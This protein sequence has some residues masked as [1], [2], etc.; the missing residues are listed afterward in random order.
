MKIR[1]NGHSSFT[2]ITDDGVIIVT[3]PYESGAFGGG[4][5]YFPVDAEPDIV[6]ISHNHAD[7][8][9][10]AGFKG[11]FEEVRGDRTI[12]G[13][14]F[15]SIDTYHD[16]N[17]GADRG[18]NKIFCFTI[19]D[20]NVCH[21]GDLGHTLSADQIEKLGSVDVMFMPVGGFYTIDAKQATDIFEKVRPKI[22]IPMH[23]KTEKCGFP[24]A[25]VDEFSRG[26]ARV[27]RIDSDEI[28]LSADK[29]PGEPE[30]IILKH[31]L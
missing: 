14:E 28:E 22:A 24:I 10:T 31:R 2:I 18:D 4:I 17:Q 5:A 15:K 27:Q 25:D 9:Y 6:T 23:F 19:D 29:L 26:K 20:I 30:I 7:H 1:W 13:I 8:N 16:T 11:E 12:K 21:L 3:D